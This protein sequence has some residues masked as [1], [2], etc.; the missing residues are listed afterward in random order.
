ML[1]MVA[2]PTTAGTGSDAQSYALISTDE[3]HRK[4]ACGDPR[5]RFRTVILDPSVTDTLPRE[6]AAA[7]ALDAVSHALESFVATNRC[8]ASSAY[9]LQAWNIL[10]S[11]LV[12]ALDSPGDHRLWGSMQVAAHLAGAAI[13][14]SML[15]AAHACAN[16]LTAHYRTTHGVA[17]VLMLPHVIRY[18]APVAGTLYAELCQPTAEETAADRLALRVEAMIEAANQPH[19]LSELGVERDRLPRLAAEAASQWTLQF[20]PRPATTTD[21][22]GIYE[23]AF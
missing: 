5:A 2:V 23:S 22:L 3:T 9:A 17:V 11:H 6:I 20:N 15:G 1:P 14:R 21:L 13:E 18:N 10:D 19:K 16:P 7:S 8:E 12:T 4:M